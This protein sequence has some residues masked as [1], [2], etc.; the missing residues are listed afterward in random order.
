MDAAERKRRKAARLRRKLARRK[1]K[2]PLGIDSMAQRV[3]GEM[4]PM[5]KLR[6]DVKAR[7][8][9]AQKKLMQAAAKR[10]GDFKSRKRWSS[11]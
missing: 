7:A 4:P 2:N 6:G 1:L 10:A 5:P 3:L 11:T 9:R 8:K